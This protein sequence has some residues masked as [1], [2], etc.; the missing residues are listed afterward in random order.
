MEKLSAIT[1]RHIAIAA[2][3]IGAGL[4]ALHIGKAILGQAAVAGKDILPHTPM[5]YAAYQS[6]KSR[7]AIEG[8]SQKTDKTNILLEDLVK[9][10]KDSQKPKPRIVDRQEQMPY[11]T[12]AH[13]PFKAGW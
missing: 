13:T 11:T 12:I 6:G 2:G 4:G 1:A 10:I 5:L 9:T 3:L 8:I 7:Q